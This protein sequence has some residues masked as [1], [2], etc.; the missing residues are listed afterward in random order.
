MSTLEENKRL[1]RRFYIEP[2]EDRRSCV[3][4]ELVTD[5]YADAD[6]ESAGSSLAPGHV[7]GVL[8]FPDFAPVS[9]ALRQMAG[10]VCLFVGGDGDPDAWWG[11]AARRL[12]LT[13]GHEVAVLTLWSPIAAVI[14][15]STVAS[16]RL[17]VQPVIAR[18]CTDHGSGLGHVRWVS[19]R[20]S[21]WLHNFRRLRIRWERDAG[22]HYALLSPGCSRDLLAPHPIVRRPRSLLYAWS[23]IATASRLS[24]HRCRS[25]ARADR[26]LA[27]AWFSSQAGVS[28]DRAETLARR[29]RRA[30]WR[31]RGPSPM[32]VGCVSSRRP[33]AERTNCGAPLKRPADQSK[34]DRLSAFTRRSPAA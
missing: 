33:P 12:A 19:D 11:D 16:C 23:L 24:S 1:A 32:P 18:R 17:G 26:A 28:G 20:T 25:E 30:L 8:G 3:L 2:L 27:D 13:L 15:T 22:L 4:D 29:G 7:H 6:A 10:V 31:S 34:A 21:A 5:D 14:T 9:P